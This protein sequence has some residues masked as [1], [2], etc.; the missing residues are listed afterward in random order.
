MACGVGLG[1]PRQ[2]SE[3]AY[4]ISCSLYFYVCLCARVLRACTC[5]TMYHMYNKGCVSVG[6][7]V[8]I[9]TETQAHT[10]TQYPRLPGQAQ[11][12]ML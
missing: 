1:S 4:F 6:T 7:C 10:V 3:P 2:V 5:I 9:H 11:G 12:I 8:H